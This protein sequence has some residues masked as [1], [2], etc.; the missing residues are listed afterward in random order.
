MSKQDTIFREM[1]LHMRQEHYTLWRIGIV[2]VDSEPTSY[3]S[4][5]GV[6]RGG[7]L[8]AGR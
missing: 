3:S 8:E 5:D 1:E 7:S 6:S 2:L 4:E